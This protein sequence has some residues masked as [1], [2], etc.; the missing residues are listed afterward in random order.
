[1]IVDV[2]G[3]MLVTANATVVIVT[4]AWIATVNPSAR[5]ATTASATIVDVVVRAVVQMA[6]VNVIR[7]SAKC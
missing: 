2:L 7:A 5:T 3:V 6:N 4:I 1:M